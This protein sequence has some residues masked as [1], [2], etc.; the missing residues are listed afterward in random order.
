MRERTTER[1]NDEVRT[2]HVRV[3]GQEYEIIERPSGKRD[4]T[5]AKDKD[6]PLPIDHRFSILPE[7]SFPLAAGFSADALN[8]SWHYGDGETT[9]KDHS[10]LTFTYGPQGIQK[11]QR[12]INGAG[13]NEYT[14]ED[15]LQVPPGIWIPA[16]CRYRLLPASSSDETVF[17]LHSA[18]F[19]KPV[20][21]ADFDGG[22]YVP[23]STINDARVDPPVGWAY[24]QLAKATGK[25][26]GLTPEAL[27]EMSKKRADALRPDYQRRQRANQKANPDGPSPATVMIGLFVAV[28]LASL[29]FVVMRNHRQSKSKGE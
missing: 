15:S 19:G 13:T 12:W 8:G 20:R 28:F 21:D 1:P 2:T 11:V 24:E 7:P 18:D 26:T 16:R 23:G 14:Y 10:R 25:K 5:F 29:G 9:L 17:T 4:V 22:W 3:R 6:W 27:L